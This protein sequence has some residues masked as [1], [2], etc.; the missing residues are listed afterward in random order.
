ML[1]V[2]D[3]YKMY[4]HNATQILIDLDQSIRVSNDRLQLPP[5]QLGFAKLIYITSFLYYIIAAIIS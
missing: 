5:S 3:M 2:W 1:E 4:E